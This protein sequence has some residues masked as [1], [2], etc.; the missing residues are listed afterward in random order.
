M[1][2]IKK[3]DALDAPGK[4]FDEK[5]YIVL[6]KMNFNEDNYNTYEL[7][8]GME[9]IDQS[10]WG[11]WKHRFLIDRNNCRA[12]EVMNGDMN[13]VNFTTEDIDWNSIAEL[14][15]K[16]KIRAVNL[17]AGFPTFIGHFNNGVAEVS[18]Q[19]NPDGRYYMDDSGYGMSDDEE[20]TLYGFID[21][22]MNVLVK[23]QYIGKDYNRLKEMRKEAENCISK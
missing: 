7:G 10:K 14:P 23:F 8:E 22:E 15:E 3:V 21:K 19:I 2:V 1:N 6:Q 11:W 16:A 5:L 4:S 13:F 9:V 18:W 17:S 12:Y 20:L